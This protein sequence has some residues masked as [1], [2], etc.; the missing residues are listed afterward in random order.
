MFSVDFNHANACA[1][2]RSLVEIHNTL[3]YGVVNFQLLDSLRK[4]LFDE[5]ACL[6]ICVLKCDHS[7][8]LTVS[9]KII[10][11]EAPKE[12]FLCY[13][14]KNNW[15]YGIELYNRKIHKAFTLWYILWAVPKWG[16]WWIYYK[17]KYVNFVWQISGPPPPCKWCES[18]KVIKMV[19]CETAQDGPILKK[20]LVRFI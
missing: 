4:P 5:H 19:C 8:L 2:I 16:I 3:C 9:V 6:T 1:S 10:V 20:K 12:T 15:K 7:C 11:L 14:H 17:I 13:I 18:G